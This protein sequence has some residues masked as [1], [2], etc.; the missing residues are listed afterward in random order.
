MLVLTSG[1][2]G[3][4][5]YIFSRG[6]VCQVS[7]LWKLFCNFLAVPPL[8]SAGETTLGVLHLVLGSPAQE[9]N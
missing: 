5:P 2:S 9:A 8:F 4:P 6:T 1:S 7:W 3:L